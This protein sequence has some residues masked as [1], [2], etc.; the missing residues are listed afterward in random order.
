MRYAFPLSVLSVALL[1]VG[2]GSEESSDKSYRPA[3]NYQQTTT[4]PANGNGYSPL[5]N[6][7]NAGTPAPAPQNGNAGQTIQVTP[8]TTTL[9][10]AAS[11]PAAGLNPAHGQPGHR[12]DI[13]V[14][15]P[16]NSAPAAAPAITTTPATTTTA[17]QPV[18]IN[19][20]TPAAKPV[21]KGM[22]PEHGQPG[23]RCDIAVGAPLDSKPAAAPATITTTPVTTTAP[24]TTPMSVTPLLPA[25]KE[26]TPVAA[27]MNPEH[28]KPGHRC[29]IAVGAPLNSAPAQKQ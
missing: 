18:V 12:C 10:P 26:A 4:A 25:K 22:N 13:A 21:A 17:S 27:G 20:T 6:N 11:L 1:G 28:G 16:L 14:G 2:C 5:M 9:Q 3:P 24:A 8:T 15:A 19:N 7:N 29:D 23:H